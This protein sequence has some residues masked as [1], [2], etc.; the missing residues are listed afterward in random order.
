VEGRL[1]VCPKNAYPQEVD[2]FFV[3]LCEFATVHAD[4]TFSVVRGGIEHWTASA[5]PFSLT[6]WLL[7]SVPP[8]I[9]PS[10]QVTFKIVLKL[11]SGQIVGA[12]EG[13]ANV[14][15]PGSRADYAIPLQTILNEYGA[16]GLEILFGDHRIEKRLELKQPTVVSP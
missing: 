15:E 11:P 8:N 1:A 2:P 13:L 6:C 16:L 7:V 5:L 14:R 3:T 12:V 10:G 9:L 4:G